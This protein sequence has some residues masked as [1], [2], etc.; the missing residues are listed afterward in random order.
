MCQSSAL[1]AHARS[2]VAQAG[3]FDSPQKLKRFLNDAGEHV[4][5]DDE[6]ELRLHA[7]RAQVQKRMATP[8]AKSTCSSDLASMPSVKEC[9]E[10]VNEVH[11][12]KD[13][14]VAE[15]L[16]RMVG[17]LVSMSVNVHVWRCGERNCTG[18]RRKTDGGEIRCNRCGSDKYIECFAI[19]GT[20]MDYN[21]EAMVVNFKVESCTASPLLNGMTPARFVRLDVEAQD[22]LATNQVMMPFIFSVGVKYCGITFDETT[23]WVHGASRLAA[24]RAKES[25][26][27]KSYMK[28]FM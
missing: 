28:K 1:S 20:I 21:N 16:P 27:L 6:D 17:I 4:N 12:C 19:D 24:S 7:L 15:R 8:V 13:V 3:K 18:K 5:E 23:V 10:K 26:S 14:N 2:C 22:S 11:L 25:P 9:L